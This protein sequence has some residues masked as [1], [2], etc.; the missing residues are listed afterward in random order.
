MKYLIDTHV[1]LWA[2]YDSKQ[3]SEMARKILND[4]R[5]MISIASLWEISI[6]MSIGKLKLRQT[7]QEL[8]EFCSRYGI[9]IVHITPAYC[10]T[11]RQLPFIHS[12]PFDRIIIATAKDND[13]TILTKDGIIP[14]Y[15]IRTVW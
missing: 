5:C 7:V 6:K 2:V 9:D 14:K 10:D 11:M 12:D 13:Y 15:D 3:L 8:A 4:E 1:L